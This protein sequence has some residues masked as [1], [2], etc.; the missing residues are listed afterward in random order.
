MARITLG[1]GT[2]HGPM[3]STPP[4]IWPQRVKADRA[5]PQHFF[6]GK[7]Y[8]FDQLVKLRQAENFAAQIT[9][10]VSRERH[11]RCRQAMPAVRAQP[12]RR[13]EAP[14]CQRTT[15]RDRGRACPLRSR[16]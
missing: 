8:T 14:H 9:P 1:L 5:N 7:T 3:L 12:A 15:C 10:E 6:K 4:E 11:A 16:H 13:R 2:S